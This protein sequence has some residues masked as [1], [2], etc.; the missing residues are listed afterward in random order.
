MGGT[1][2]NVLNA[3]ASAATPP[4]PA[5]L[6]DDTITGAASSTSS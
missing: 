2:A 5:D 3:S 1:G 4:S 6:G